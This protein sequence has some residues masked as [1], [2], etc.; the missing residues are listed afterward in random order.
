VVWKYRNEGVHEIP[1]GFTILF[2]KD[3]NRGIKVWALVNPNAKKVKVA[4][5]IIRTGAEVPKGLKYAGSFAGSPTRHIFI[6][7]PARGESVV[8]EEG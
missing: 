5:R 3:S 7:K 8:N 1:K 2:G 4:L 6:G